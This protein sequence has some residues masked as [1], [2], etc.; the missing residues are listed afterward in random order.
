[1]SRRLQFWKT[2]GQGYFAQHPQNSRFWFEVSGSKVFG[3]EL[4]ANAGQEY[5]LKDKSAP[6]RI[7]FYVKVSRNELS[8]GSTAQGPWQHNQTME[9][10]ESRCLF[11]APY[12]KPPRRVWKFKGG[13]FEEVCDGQVWQGK[14]IWEE[15]SCF[16]L[17]L[18]L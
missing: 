13:W 12:G 14:R 3:Y 11:V 4:E 2:D 16:L 9:C 8:F 7:G 15:E 18:L 17:L 1:M 10:K 6:R 5:I